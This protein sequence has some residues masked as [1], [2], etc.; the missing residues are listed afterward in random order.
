MQQQ[1]AKLDIQQQ[2]RTSPNKPRGRSLFCLSACICERKIANIMTTLDTLIRAVQTFLG[3]DP[4]GTAGQITWKAIYAKLT[5]KAWADPEPDVPAIEGFPQAAV[6]LILEAEGIDQPAKWPGGESG[7]TLGYG[8]DIGADPKSLEYWR[9]ILSDHQIKRLAVAKGK[10]GNAAAAIARQFSD[11]NISKTDALRVF[12][13]HTLPLEIALT[14][15]TYPGIDLLPPTVLG[16]MTSIVYNRGPS[17]AGGNRSEMRDI[18]DVITQFANT[19]PQS[20]DVKATLEKI[21]DLIQ[22]M[23]RLWVGKGLDGLLTRRD[24][25]A[26]L[27]RDTP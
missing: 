2:T 27:I 23:K 1:G 3:V 18:K 16:A 25:E 11:I 13:T 17:L 8:C 26:K 6:S 20:R 19:P 7:I 15:Q 9:G 12:M 5:G 10:T 21:A 24:A 22:A 14:R 4:D